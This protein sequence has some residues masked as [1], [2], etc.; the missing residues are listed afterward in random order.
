[1]PPK[2]PKKNRPKART[3][4]VFQRTCAAVLRTRGKIKVTIIAGVFLLA[5]AF[6]PIIFVNP[7]G[8]KPQG[9]DVHV[10]EIR[11]RTTVGQTSG[12]NSP[13]VVKGNVTYN[14]NPDWRNADSGAGS[15]ADHADFDSERPQ[16]IH[17]ESPQQ[18]CRRLLA[19]AKHEMDYGRLEAAEALIE[20]A[21]MLLDHL[22]G[23]L[24]PLRTDLLGALAKLRLLQGRLDIAERLQREV[25]DRYENSSGQHH[26]NAW[27]AKSSLASI[28]IDSG[29]HTEAEALLRDI[30]PLQAQHLGNQ[31]DD[32]LETVNRLGELLRVSNRAVEAEVLLESYLKGPLASTKQSLVL[33][34]TLA[35]ALQAQGRLDEAERVMRVLVQDAGELLGQDHPD[36]VR[37]LRNYALFM[38]EQR[39]FAIAEPLAREA[40]RRTDRL[41]GPSSIEALIARNNLGFVV[42]EQGR[43]A[44]ALPR[45]QEVVQRARQGLPPEHWALPPFTAS[46][47]QCFLELGR[48]AEAEAE[49]L[50]AFEGF[51]RLGGDDHPSARRV[52]ELLTRLYHETGRTPSG[53]RP[54]EPDLDLSEHLRAGEVDASDDITVE[55][56]TAEGRR[57][58]P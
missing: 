1:M 54:S 57:S 44:E 26:A 53:E 18:S 24:H 6:V 39:K 4:R 32:T 9:T 14:I 45:F 52:Q 33:Y 16:D 51:C 30:Q 41:Y 42:G 55:S 20:R 48:Y 2:R 22:I 47:G 35:G 37:Y 29:G 15:Q 5:T 17:A 50:D 43:H 46:L 25:V 38:T 34:N 7:S 11:S 58:V 28:L 31:H 49:L 8:P 21:E 40:L 12:E 10:Q 3:Q 23:P 56:K 36:S 27:Q 13:A 19:Q